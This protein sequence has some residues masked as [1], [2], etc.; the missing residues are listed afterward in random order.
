MAYE[1]DGSHQTKKE[2]KAFLQVP[3]VTDRQVANL[4]AMPFSQSFP[5]RLHDSQQVL[6]E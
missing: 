3:L 5:E 6:N 4:T 2:A 1:Q